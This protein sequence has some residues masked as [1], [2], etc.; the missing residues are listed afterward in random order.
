MI[1]LPSGRVQPRDGRDDER[2]E[3][4][5]IA[6]ARSLDEI[7]LLHGRPRD[8]SS[9]RVQGYWRRPDP[10][11]F[12]APSARGRAQWLGSLAANLLDRAASLA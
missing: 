4:V 3:G 8:A 9:G 6:P 12:P 11:P 2:I 7:P 10:D 5:M 1:V